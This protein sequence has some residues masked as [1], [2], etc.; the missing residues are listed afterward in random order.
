VAKYSNQGVK[1]RKILDASS[2]GP[3]KTTFFFP[4]IVADSGLQLQT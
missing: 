2:V 4:V 1:A 3:F